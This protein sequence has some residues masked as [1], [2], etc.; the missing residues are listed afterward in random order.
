MDPE[1]LNI[2]ACPACKANVVFD[3]NKIV[4]LECNRAYPIED[5]IPIMMT[6]EPEKKDT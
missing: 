4:C 3:K 1:L 6:D 2:I 5:G